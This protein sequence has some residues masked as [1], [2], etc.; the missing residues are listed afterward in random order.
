MPARVLQCCS[1]G[2]RAE[3]DKESCCLVSCK[4]KLQFRLRGEYAKQ[5]VAVIETN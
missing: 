2:N 4:H 5:T 1:R 3:I